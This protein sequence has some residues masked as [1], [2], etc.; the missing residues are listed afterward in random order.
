MDIKML[1]CTFRDGGY[2][3]AWDF[4]VP[5]IH[6]Y[7][8]AMDDN[9]IDYVELGFRSL[10]NSGFNGPCA[11]TTDDFI[12]SLGVPANIK[13]GVMVNSSEL[14]S[15]PDGMEKALEK[16]FRPKKESPVTLVRLACHFPEF[17]PSLS[18]GAWLKKQGYMVGINIM[19]IS[20]RSRD[21]I[22]KAGQLA[23]SFPLDVLYFADSF[24]GMNPKMTS[25]IIHALGRHWKGEIGIHTHDSMGLALTNTMQAISDGVTWVDSTVTGMGRGPGNAKTEYLVVEM[26][27]HRKAGHSLASMMSVVNK[28]FKPMQAK[29][30][31]GSNV[32]Y[33]LAGKYQIH[34]TY[35][36]EMLTNPS[37][38]DEDIIAAIE[39][40][41]KEGGKKYKHTTLEVARQ[42]YRGEPVGR[43]E[44]SSKI[45]GRD[46]MILGTGPGATKYQEAIEAFVRKNKP[47]VIALNTESHIANDLVDLRVACHPVRLLSDSKKYPSYP[48]PLVTPFSML[49]QT[50]QQS[51]K[52]KEV[53]DYGL[54]VEA[55]QLRL[56]SMFCVLPSPLVFAYAVA[57]AF[58]GK[59]AKV[60]LAGFDGYGAGDPRTAEVDDLLKLFMSIPGMPEILSITPTGYK[61]KVVSLYA[62]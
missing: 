55:G 3:N 29:Y 45:A 6:D 47:L 32:Y 18:C 39:F 56:E 57:I 58:V 27:Q 24:G 21:E 41:R 11:F 31:W 60:Y 33:H 30:G 37:F 43:W 53:L 46:V 48:Q 7:L 26:D 8:R 2:Y 15:H 52:G 42:F 61:I 13:V 59:A 12:R 36:Q 28:H 17:E 19:Q 20:D 9:H 34:P 54:K 22:E 51:L 44:P 23:S 38:S 50:V 14:V 5:L 10:K 35:V 49:P 16:L 40:L 1:D 62:M 4:S 25:D